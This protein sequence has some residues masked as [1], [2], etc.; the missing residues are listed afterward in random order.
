V[1]N[2][3]RSVGI[4]VTADN[5]G[6]TTAMRD[7]RREMDET[8]KTAERSSARTGKASAD[9]NQRVKR[10]ND[11]TRSSLKATERAYRDHGDAG[12]GA[13]TRVGASAKKL[14]GAAGLGLI[15]KQVYDIG[16]G[17]L[18]FKQNSEL[19]FTTMLGSGDKARTFLADILAFAKETPFAF[20]D[21]TDSAQRMLAFGIETEKVIP[22][23]RTL[24]DTALGTGGGVEKMNGIVTAISQISAK[25]RVQSEELLQLSERGV[26]AL[27]ILANQ[28]GKTAGALQKDITKGLIDADQ[29]IDWL[30]DGL[31]NGTQGINGTTA[32]FGGLMEQVKGSGGITA[33]FDSAKSSFRNMAGAIMEGLAPSIITLV[34]AG[35]DLMSVIGWLAGEFADLPRPIRDAALAVGALV[36]AKR[37]L[38]TEM[39][40]GMTGALRS[41][42]TGI[43]DSVKAT[44][45]MNLEMGAARTS[46]ALMKAGAAGLGTALMGA[47]G[48]PVGIAIAAVTLGLSAYSSTAADAKA[49]TDEL[50]ATL[51]ETGNATAETASLIAEK[52]AEV[53]EF[54]LGQKLKKNW[55]DIGE[56]TNLIDDAKKIGL[57]ATTLQ[58]A[59]LKN[60][61]ALVASRAAIRE[62]MD[63][64]D[65]FAA[66]RIEDFL[67]SQI[68]A[69]DSATKAA[70]DKKAVDEAGAKSTE[71][72]G[73]A[74]A[75]TARQSMVLRDE[76]GKLTAAGQA[77]QDASE[78]AAKAFSSGTS[79]M[80][81][82][83][84]LSTDKDVENARDAVTKATNSVKDAEGSLSKARSAKKPDA[85][86]IRRAEQ[87][88]ADARKAAKEA[89]D[90]LADTEKRNDPVGQYRRQLKQQ[91]KD[92]EKFRDDMIKLAER[93]LN[94]Q[95]LQELLTQGVEGSADT[96]KALLGDKKLIGKTN[97]FQTTM[98]GLA[99]EIET[100]A[101]V[102]A[103]RLNTA[104]GV[105]AE[106]FNL[107]L[108][109]AMEGG[110]EKSLSSLANKL[111]EDPSK[112]REVGRLLGIE[113]VAGFSDAGVPWAPGV[114]PSEPKRF[115]FP[116]GFASGGIYPGYTPGRDIGFIG[117]SGGEAIMRPEFTRAVGP[118]WVH[119]MNALARSVGAAGV[120]REMNRYLGGF[121]N[122]GVPVPQHAAPQVI[123][124]TESQTVGYPMTVENLTVQSNNAADLERQLR[125][126]RRRAFTGGRP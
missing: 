118:D 32:A 6:V 64:G 69:L 39:G 29:A 57:A 37:L 111:G 43:G 3:M 36:I 51:D 83:L 31:E 94:G 52:M 99:G 112:I 54:D 33:T 13:F 116:Q 18:E 110:A 85:E 40:V 35:T 91:Q 103:A 5:K 114:T 84:N 45:S 30:V 73:N 86:T 122:G 2:Q 62:A 119:K 27:R 75:A 59:A 44:R 95:S 79:P 97:D 77:V 113:F 46:M 107:G 96:R 87:S 9:A 76:M 71:R 123:R 126:Q 66:D 12:E 125:A 60:A 117:V 28:A 10:A 22:I 121:A 1:N 24:G 11:D 108:R 81:M 70:Q 16:M 106:E 93:G 67:E 23:L 58:D 89:S 26:P 88:L 78:A 105:T 25:G 19:A 14:A 82:K 7:V 92:A 100:L 124:L 55:G 34:N 101:R 98:D 65:W 102:N 17:F 120:Q 15:G 4:R 104:G 41:Y 61:D 42:A 38:R 109:V 49:R 80:S 53:R 56:G 8:A 20:T 74:Y 72:L 47:F 21:L 90:N 68:G 115:K 50:K 48:G 63:N